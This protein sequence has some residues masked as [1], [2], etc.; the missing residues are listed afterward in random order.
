M[1]LLVTAI[2]L[3]QL[4]CSICVCVCAGVSL[5]LSFSLSV[6]VFQFT[7]FL[8]PLSLS[9]Y[10]TRTVRRTQDACSA[11]ILDLIRQDHGSLELLLQRSIDLLAAFPRASCSPRRTM[12]YVVRQKLC[13]ITSIRQGIAAQIKRQILVALNQPNP[14]I[15]SHTCPS[16]KA[17]K[18]P[19]KN[20]LSNGMSGK[21]MVHH[22]VLGPR[23]EEV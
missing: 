22:T 2:E 21:A 20:N 6:F 19:Q 8:F 15:M 23:M 13:L 5:S 10:K 17:L 18:S 16:C 7:F 11:V 4:S 3:Q 12:Q 1:L 9:L 14:A